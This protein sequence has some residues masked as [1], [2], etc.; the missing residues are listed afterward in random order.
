MPALLA[1]ATL[2]HTV[3]VWSMSSSRPICDQP[4][5]GSKLRLVAPPCATNSSIASP[6]RVAAGTSAVK[7]RAFLLVV[8]WPTKLIP[9]T[10]GPSLSRFTTFSSR[11]IFKFWFPVVPGRSLLLLGTR[12]FRAESP[13]RGWPSRR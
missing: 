7:L 3:V 8:D 13:A 10:G 6:G 4:N 5:P 2:L 9:P 1:V 12:T 11:T